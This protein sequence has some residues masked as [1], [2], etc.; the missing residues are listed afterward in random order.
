[1]AIILE[2]P[3]IRKLAKDLIFEEECIFSY[4]YRG[5]LDELF[6]CPE[7]VIEVMEENDWFGAV[8]RI[9]E[10]WVEW[11]H[12]TITELMYHYRHFDIS[13]YIGT[14]S[15]IDVKLL[16]PNALIVYEEEYYGG[17][18]ALI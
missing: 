1:M 16:L 4:V 2:Q 9:D 18:T 14:A 17:G 11:M 12:T 5:L 3:F 7:D 8:N 6:N 15:I 10:T 13:K